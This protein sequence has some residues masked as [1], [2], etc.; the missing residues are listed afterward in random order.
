MRTILLT[1]GFALTAGTLLAQAALQ[2]P[3]PAGPPPTLEEVRKGM[4]IPSQD[5]VRGQQDKVGF[6]STREQMAKVWELSAKPP[7]PEPLGPAP[8]AGVAGVICPHD[9]Y[10]YAGRVYRQVLPLVTARTIV[11]VGV[12]HK[13]RR[14]GAHDVLVFDSYH[15]WRTPDGNVPPSGV[16]EEL[17]ALLPKGDFVRDNAAHDSEHSL[18]ALAYW[19]KHTDP[20]VQIIPVIVPA[21]RFARMR[22]LADHLAAALAQECSSR[23]WQ[24]GRDIA[25]VISSDAVHY[26]ADFK[27]TPF[28]EGGIEAYSKAVAQDRALLT[29]PLAGKVEDARVEQFFATCVNPEQPGEYRLTWCGR[30]SIPFGML[31]LE[32]LAL[33]L[34]LAAPLAHPLCYGTSIGAPE[35]PVRDL[36]MGATAQA[37]LYH[38]VGYPAVAFTVR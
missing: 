27:Y 31:L 19:L 22:E 21:M 30:F 34:G 13:Y 5:E 25:V 4:G 8:A 2:V 33:K 9:D 15:A 1:L 17:L 12:F 26:G 6:A 14:F 11:L 10:L 28:G 7:A 20:E 18:E 23:R 32:K 3:T 37:N 16:R 35:L 29:G 38:F 24:L 36:G